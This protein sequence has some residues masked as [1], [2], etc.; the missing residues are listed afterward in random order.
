MNRI[1]DIQVANK[2]YIAAHQSSDLVRKLRAT[3][4]LRDLSFGLPGG[5]ATFTRL[6]AEVA[7][8]ERELI[9]ASECN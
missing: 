9:R 3:Q 6:C 7:K 2:E 4:I 1:I 8:L 5:A